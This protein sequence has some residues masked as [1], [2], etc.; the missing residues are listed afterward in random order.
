MK[1]Y[2]SSFDDYIQSV[3][4][5]NIHPELYQTFAKFP[6]NIY[7]IEN[8]IIYGPSGIGKYSQA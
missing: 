1:Y 5:H 2:E 8:S 6:D 3:E 4:K 7:H